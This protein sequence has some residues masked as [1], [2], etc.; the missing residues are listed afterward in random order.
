MLISIVIVTVVDSCS[1][2]SSEMVEHRE[3]E[4]PADAMSNKQIHL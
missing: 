3:L 4:A 1:A 2:S